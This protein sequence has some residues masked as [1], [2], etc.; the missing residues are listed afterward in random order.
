MGFFV[1]NDTI[2]VVGCGAGG[3]TAAQFARKTNRKKSVI[4]FEKGPYPQYSKCGLPYSIE[5]VIPTPLHLIEFSEEWFSKANIKLHLNTSVAS[6][7]TKHKTITAKMAN[8]TIIEH[9]YDSLI[10]ATGSTPSIP[11]INNIKHN[12]EFVSGIFTIRTIDDAQNMLEYLPNTKNVTIIGAGLIGMEM[13]DCLIKKGKNVT[14]VEALPNILPILDEDIATE[15]EKIIQGKL[16]LYKNNFAIGIITKDNRIEEVIIKDRSSN[17]EQSISTD[18]LIIA[19]GTKPEVT[20]AKNI[21]CSIG[22]TGGIKVNNKSETSV[23]DIYAVGD[24]TEY[25]D[26]ITK[27]PVLIGLGSIAVRQGIAAGTNAAGGEYI[28][29]KGVLQTFTSEFFDT[30]IAGV[31]PSYAHLKSYEIISG[32]YHGSSLPNYFPGGKPILM[33]ILIDSKTGRILSAQAVGENAAQR[34]NT[35]ATAILSDMSIDAFRKL[36]TAYAPPVAPTLDVV[37]LT[38]DIAHMRLQRKKI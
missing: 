15:I 18:I 14:F 26:Y 31:G 13:A 3:G 37:T 23:N 30:Q 4:I 9:E 19:T 2:I 7:N 22:V 27:K 1:S 28:L 5:G 29:P 36:E 32:R 35:Y 25:T 8:E 21:G 33:K 34:I 24:C 20:L 16:S 12:D 11:S 38:A 10:I 6:I 17:K